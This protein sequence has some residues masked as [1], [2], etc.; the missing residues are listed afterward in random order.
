MNALNYLTEVPHNWS[1]DDINVIAFKEAAK[2]IGG[3]HAVEEFL[4]NGIFPLSNDWNLMVER[5]EAPLSKVAVSLPK[6]AAMI[7]ELETKAAFETRI[8]TTAN[9][10]VGNYSPTEHRA[11]MDQLHHGRLNRIFE[12]DGVKYQ[13]RPEPI[14]R[15]L[16]QRKGLEVEVVL[17]KI[18]GL[19]W[20]RGASSWDVDKTSEQELLLAKPLK[21]SK[22]SAKGWK[23][24][25]RA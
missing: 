20:W 13:S 7:D 18:R 9:H 19:K 14:S 10:M 8:A 17:K 2:I 4:A 5:A 15:G 24:A 22:K 12:L 16:R 21:P 6:V 23:P 3:W 25:L 1:A 11:C